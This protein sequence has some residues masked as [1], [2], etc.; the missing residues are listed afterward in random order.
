[1]V[2]QEIFQSGAVPSDTDFRIFR[3]FGNIPGI[4]MAYVAKGYVYHTEYDTIEQIDNGTVQ[5]AGINLLAIVKNLAAQEL[6]R[7]M[8][9]NVVF[10][11]LFGVFM[12]HYPAWAGTV[13][14]SLC[15]VLLVFL[16]AV[17]LRSRHKPDQEELTYGRFGRLLLCCAG[18]SIISILLSLAVSAGVAALL[19][20]LHRD[21]SWFSSP[22]LLFLLYSVPTF[23]VQL[24]S[25]SLLPHL[26][27]RRRTV[28][29]SLLQSL[30]LHCQALLLALLLL[31][32][33]LFDVKSAFLVS[34]PVFLYS[35]WLLLDTYLPDRP[36]LSQLLLVFLQAPALLLTCYNLQLVYMFF[37]PV[38]G[39]WGTATS[40][41]LLLGPATALFTCYLQHMYLPLLYSLQPTARRLLLLLLALMWLTSLLATIF[42][43]ISFPFTSNPG[44]RRPQRLTVL[45]AGVKGGQGAPAAGQGGL[46]V[47]RWDHHWASEL[48]EAVQQ[49][50]EAVV[51]TTRLCQQEE[52][53]VCNSPD[54][55][56]G[57][58]WLE[59]QGYL[60]EEG[61]GLREVGR[62]VEGEVVM[63]E[64]ELTG[65]ERLE[66]EARVTGGGE[67]VGG[68]RR[69]RVSVVRGGEGRVSRLELVLRVA[70]GLEGKV[71]L[72]VWL[73]GH[74]TTEQVSSK[75]EFFLLSIDRPR[76]WI[77]LLILFIF[78]CCIF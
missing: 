58:L 48:E 64:L 73:S 19:S 76:V 41:D 5:R 47:Q 62:R 13:L 56:E 34:L 38:M 74:H 71:E 54:W 2:G 68:G 59:G 39:R 67:F 70:G 7:K 31:P 43:P 14:N 10:F 55:R 57:N 72:E 18:S 35:L 26:L 78:C 17:D 21:M 28:S 60:V 6:D 24:A 30:H 15:L 49:Y 50:R 27:A 46:L 29:G 12:V 36:V 53:L 8:E 4:D 45:H 65:P 1:M 40:P 22:Y 37:I 75:I 63:L 61:S 23:G 66:L 33:I 42:S 11:D 77:D 32:L 52:L 9:T 16:I 25:C 69:E 51:L 20:T 44:E 3:D